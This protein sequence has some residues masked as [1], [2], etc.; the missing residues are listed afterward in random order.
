M[1]KK[2]V[3][4]SPREIIELMIEIQEDALFAEGAII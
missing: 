1:S 4:R 2:I 3:T